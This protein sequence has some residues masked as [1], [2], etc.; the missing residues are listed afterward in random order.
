MT[1]ARTN[2]HKPAETASRPNEGPTTASSIIR[3]GAGN[4]PALRMLAK[5]CASSMVMSP[6]EIE[7]RPFGIS[8][9]TTG[10]EYT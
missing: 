7:E 6:P 4:L 3:D 8:S 5:S 9:F 10:N 2:D 1:K